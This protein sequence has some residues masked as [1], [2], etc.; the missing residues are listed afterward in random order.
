MNSRITEKGLTLQK[1]FPNEP[2]EIKAD[3]DKIKQVVLNLLSNA[4]KYN[5]PAGKIILKARTQ[6]EGIA[7]SVRD[8]GPGI[9]TENLKNLFQKFY[10]VPG[11]E[12]MATGTGLGLSICKN[13]IEAH[14][15]TIWVQSEV[16]RG[17]EFCV[18]LPVHRAK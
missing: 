10:R 6:S 8:T 4:I 17:T 18:F 14:G 1:A 5:S 12:K 7:F 11:T 3:R 2:L 16:G 13:I 15:G 9:S